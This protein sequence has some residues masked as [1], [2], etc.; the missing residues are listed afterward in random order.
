MFDDGTL[1]SPDL[2]QAIVSGTLTRRQ[3]ATAEYV[4]TFIPAFVNIFRVP[5]AAYTPSL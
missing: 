5:S 1:T 3:L 4:R 2:F